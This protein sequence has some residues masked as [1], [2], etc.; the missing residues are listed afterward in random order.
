MMREL[1]S[2]YAWLLP[3]LLV[4]GLAVAELIALQRGRRRKRQQTAGRS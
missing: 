2:T 4:L 1:L 3:E